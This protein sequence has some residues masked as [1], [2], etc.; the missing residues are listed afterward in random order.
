[1]DSELEPNIGEVKKWLRMAC[2]D[3]CSLAARSGR[4]MKVRS[5]KAHPGVSLGRDLLDFVEA[6]EE[7]LAEEP[8][9]YMPLVEASGKQGYGVSQ[10]KEHNTD[11]AGEGQTNE[12]PQE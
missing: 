11:A 3:G 10:A 1:M 4:L 5:S 6:L 7:P 12:L 2:A 9:E 8:C